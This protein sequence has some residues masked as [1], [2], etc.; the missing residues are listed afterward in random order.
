M[1]KMSLFKSLLP[2][3]KVKRTSSEASLDRD[4]P[5]PSAPTMELQN[6]SLLRDM[7]IPTSSMFSQYDKR[8]L[9]SMNLEV[10]FKIEVVTNKKPTNLAHLIAPLRN[11]EIDY[12]GNV[13]QRKLWMCLAAVAAFK[14]EIGEHREYGCVFTAEVCKGVNVIFQSKREFELDRVTRWNQGVNYLT[15]GLRS[16]WT[17]RG[18]LQKTL[19]KYPSQRAERDLMEFLRM[20]GIETAS[21]ELGNMVLVID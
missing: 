1:L 12:R 14:L 5:Q 11:L 8:Q 10:D 13:N 4:I 20:M 3:K 7:S 21:D 18:E 17:F 15:D 19:V 16:D 9:T 6:V 2:K